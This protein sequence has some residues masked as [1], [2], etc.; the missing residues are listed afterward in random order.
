M[1][2]WM[3]SSVENAL[4]FAKRKSGRLFAFKTQYSSQYE[5]VDGFFR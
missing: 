5:K 2:M 1:K 3:V 4:N